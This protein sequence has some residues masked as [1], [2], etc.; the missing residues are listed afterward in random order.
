M[1]IFR[2]GEELRIIAAGDR[3]D[4]APGDEVIGLDRARP[5]SSSRPPA[6]PS[7]VRKAVIVSIVLLSLGGRS[8]HHQTQ[9]P[10]RPAVGRRA[11]AG[12]SH[13]RG[14]AASACAEIVK[15]DPPKDGYELAQGESQS[16]GSAGSNFADTSPPRSWGPLVL[17][18]IGFAPALRSTLSRSTQITEGSSTESK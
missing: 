5:R 9:A 1:F 16:K 4:A 6:R 17:S 2:P 11:D 18:V 10:T 8:D 12:A 3:L 13:R 7:R 14:C 15:V